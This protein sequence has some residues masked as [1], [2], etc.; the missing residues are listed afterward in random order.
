MKIINPSFAFI[1]NVCKI[2]WRLCEVINYSEKIKKTAKKK[3]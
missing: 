2:T 1:I 3:K